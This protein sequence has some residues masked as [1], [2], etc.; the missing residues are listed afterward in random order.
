MIEVNPIDIGYDICKTVSEG[1]RGYEVTTLPVNGVTMM[2]ADGFTD[3]RAIYYTVGIDVMSV[4]DGTLDTPLEGVALDGTPAAL[5]QDDICGDGPGGMGAY[6]NQ[7]CTVARTHETAADDIEKPCRVM[8]HELY[9]TLN[10]KP[11]L[12]DEFEHGDERELH[13]RH[14]TGSPSAAT[15]FL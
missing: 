14:S 6:D 2:E 7:V 9:G 11:P 13:H 5:T 8:S 1:H 3:I 10:G 15:L 12:V 4:A